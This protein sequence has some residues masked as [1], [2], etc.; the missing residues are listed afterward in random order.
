MEQ[1]LRRDLHP[2][3][4]TGGPL[5]AREREGGTE[6][7]EHPD[8]E[9]RDGGPVTSG[10]LVAEGGEDDAD[11]GERDGPG[12]P[13]AV[14]SAPGPAVVTREPGWAVVTRLRGRATGPAAIG[15]RAGP[16]A[17]RV[18]SARWQTVSGVVTRG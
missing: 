17:G 13:Q 15:R 10:R 3:D 2:A 7:P 16:A 8:G 4:D 18:A 14:T 11:G 12:K 1:D 6:G 5:P 9:R